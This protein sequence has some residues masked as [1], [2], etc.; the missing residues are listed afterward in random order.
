M[1]HR[2]CCIFCQGLVPAHLDQRRE[3]GEY[4]SFISPVYTQC[5]LPHVT[6]PIVFSHSHLEVKPSEGRFVG[7]EVM[8]V[9]PSG[10]RYC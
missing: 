5:F 8:A 7:S 4:Y 3:K 10:N 6:Q 2:P 9:I 1:S